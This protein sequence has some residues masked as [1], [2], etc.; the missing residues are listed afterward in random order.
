[1]SLKCQV[2]S[3]SADRR[4]VILPVQQRCRRPGRLIGAFSACAYTTT[5][6]GRGPTKNEIHL[7]WGV[8][9]RVGLGRTVLSTMEARASKALAEKSM[10]SA[11]E[12]LELAI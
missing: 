10:T 7:G 6:T 5:E 4:I 12:I 9:V 1:M 3:K 11:G 2:C 8:L